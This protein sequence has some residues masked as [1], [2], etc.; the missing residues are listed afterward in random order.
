MNQIFSIL[1]GI[2]FTF[3]L[4]AALVGFFR[5]WGKSLARLINTL[6]NFLISLFLT[7]VI[8]GAIVKY[9]TTDDTISLFGRTINITTLVKENI[10]TDIEISTEAIKF[11]TTSLIN[12]L[13]NIIIFLAFFLSLQILSLLIYF[14]V[15]L[16]LR[17]KKKENNETNQSRIGLNF[18][19][20]LE[21]TI[22]TLIVMFAILVP[23]FGVLN[24][25]DS[26]VQAI[27]NT[28]QVESASAHIETASAYEISTEN[29]LCGR[30]Y[31]DDSKFNEKVESFIDNYNIIKDKYYSS[32]VGW[33]FKFTRIEKLGNVAFNQL[34][35]VTVSNTKVNLSNEIVVLTKTIQDVTNIFQEGFDY[36]S[37]K[38]VQDLQKLYNQVTQSVYTRKIM[39]DLIPNAAQKWLNGEP[40]MS[41]E[42]VI[43]EDLRES[44]NPILNVFA[45]SVSFDRLDRNIK[46]ILNAYMVVNEHGIIT[47][48]N[49][50]KEITEI[51]TDDNTVVKEV[52][53]ELSI[54][55]EL[56]NAIPSTIKSLMKLLYDTAIGDGNF[57]VDLNEITDEINWEVEC[58][59]IQDIVS[60]IVSSYNNLTNEN[61]END[62]SKL[63]KAID[64]ARQSKVL[65]NTV[66]D[67]IV[68]VLNSNKVEVSASVKY[69]M[70][71]MIENNWD[72]P[73][74][75][76]EESFETIDETTQVVGMLSNLKMAYKVSGELV[77]VSTQ[78]E[79]E[80]EINLSN[81]SETFKDLINNDDLKNLILAIINDDELLK[82][83][84][85]DSDLIFLIK[86]IATLFLNTTNEETIE[87][88]LNA[89]QSLIEIGYLNKNVN[90][91][92]EITNAT[93]LNVMTSISSSET[94]M[95]VVNSIVNDN[96]SK[97]HINNLKKYVDS[98]FLVRVESVTNSSE[99]SSEHKAIFNSL[100]SLLKTN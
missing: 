93:I 70:I 47:Q 8:T 14:I 43:P 57:T 40:F 96:E 4:I 15:V 64:S 13:A 55:F 58:Q 79:E 21:N 23:V 86:K 26:S 52:M 82:Q 60:E 41:V 87:N 31:Y 61:E 29:Y 17:F 44:A 37:T 36:T 9:F 90:S 63:G 11:I 7:P 49:D 78:N 2:F 91:L 83:Y 92:D 51:L 45:G 99:I 19:G 10:G 89:I 74:Y 38:T 88:D 85:S 54:P 33:F 59:V 30:L 84:I 56:R 98:D 27:N 72:D 80:E 16:V 6:V 12:I 24:V 65:S 77:S 35:I 5:G 53:Q 68:A 3:I 28:S 69:S 95:S 20:A 71:S 73:D 32:P 67:F 39:E 50:G 75:R 48:I 42:N 18:V 100:F 81:Y 46:A 94:I 66:K 76:Y 22:G 62:Y 97:T 25:V 1:S 34:A